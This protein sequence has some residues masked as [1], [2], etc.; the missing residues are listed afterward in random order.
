MG[1]EYMGIDWCIPANDQRAL[2]LRYEHLWQWSR[3]ECGECNWRYHERRHR[4][5]VVL[6]RTSRFRRIATVWL[7]SWEQRYLQHC[8]IVPRPFCGGRVGTKLASSQ[9]FQCDDSD[10][11]WNH[12]LPGFRH[13]WCPSA[14]RISLHARYHVP[15]ANVFYGT[16]RLRHLWLPAIWLVFR[17]LGHHK[18]LFL[19]DDT[20]SVKLVRRQHSI[21][22]R[23]FGV[24]V[25]LLG[26]SSD[27][28]DH[29]E[30]VPCR[31]LLHMA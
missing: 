21:S 17:R 27:M 20:G 7:G 22:V 16:R 25:G 15:L 29:D 11:A 8:S 24:D 26:S 30:R 13:R 28:C 1:A 2:I 18:L 31:H 9:R 23:R 6:L 19:L 4:C 14:C 5:V 10:I 3:M 12:V